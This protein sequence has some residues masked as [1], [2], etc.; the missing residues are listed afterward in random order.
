MKK[1][2][3][4]K[5]IVMGLITTSIL[6]VTS[7]GASAE[8]KQDGTGYWYSNGSSYAKGWSKING[9]WYYFDNNGY[10]K[11]GWLYDNGNWYY[12]KKD[13]SMVASL[14]SVVLIEGKYS[15][16]AP[17][18]KWLGYDEKANLTTTNINNN[19]V[20]NTSP[21]ANSNQ[22]T[23]KEKIDY[24]YA[25]MDNFFQSGEYRLSDSEFTK[26]FAE[27]LVLTSRFAKDLLVA[28]GYRTTLGGYNGKPAVTSTT[29]WTNELNGT[30]YKIWLIG[31]ID[32]NSGNYLGVYQVYDNGYFQYN[33]PGSYHNSVD[34]TFDEKTFDENNTFEQ[35]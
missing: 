14:Y 1:L 22:L 4:K 15:T 17:D 35:R 7:I 16:F 29:I 24:N 23:A 10:M 12:L 20:F 27:S 3:L 5:I 26:E 18:G 2:N 9:W 21:S 25:H 6:G 8:W 34:K 11:T 33:T 13:G 19:T 31:V 32:K 28:G 30:V